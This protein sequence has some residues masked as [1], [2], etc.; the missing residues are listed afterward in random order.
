MTKDP[1]NPTNGTSGA[2]RLIESSAE[3]ASG[4]F[5]GLAGLASGL[6]LAGPEGALVGG[7]AGSSLTMALRWL[8]REMSSRL[9]GPREEQRLG[10][11]YTVAAAEIAERIKS[12]EHVRQDGFFGTSRS[13]R[14]D[15]EEVW[16]SILMKSQ[17][18]PEEKKLPYMA[19][20]LANLAFEPGVGAHMAH[21]ITK[22][23]EQLSYRQLCILK[24]IMAKEKYDLREN[25][26]R[27]ADGGFPPELYQLFYE[28]FDLHNRGYIHSGTG[29][30]LGLTDVN[31]S[32]VTVQG[33][34]IVT[35]QLMRLDQIPE[36]DILLI[37]EQ[38]K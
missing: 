1:A 25:N 14:S 23:A 36:A 29:T 37:A 30:M 38:M 7:A 10:Y 27:K 4:A 8:G 12:G 28:Y 2:Q 26:Y 21:Q 9:L 22:T 24:L 13:G 35:F 6:I 17:R 5:A 20:L 11:V 31:P 16:E 33:L 32:A 19:Y 18:E 34:G 15:G 3:I